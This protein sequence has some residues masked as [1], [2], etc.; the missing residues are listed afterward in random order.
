MKS[1]GK[2]GQVH[3]DSPLNISTNSRWATSYHPEPSVPI[4]VV[5][6]STC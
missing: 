2:G 3:T 5:S 6:K 4:T 1:E